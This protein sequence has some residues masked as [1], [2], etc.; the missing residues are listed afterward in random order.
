M[1]MAVNGRS[2]AAPYQ[3]PWPKEGFFAFSPFCSGR[4]LHRLRFP[5][6]SFRIMLLSDPGL[7][8]RVV[9]LS[10]RK[11]T[12]R[13][14]T[15]VLWRPVYLREIRYPRARGSP[16]RRN[17]FDARECDRGIFHSRP[18]LT[19]VGTWGKLF[20]SLTLRRRFF[21]NQFGPCFFLSVPPPSSI[22]QTVLGPLRQ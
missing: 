5:L 19:A 15:F 12:S 16:K 7:L 13:N 14:I 1:R 21:T 10:A 6:S 4:S 2:Q 3:T 18:P 11:K 17:Q 8:L 9:P 22:L 20:I